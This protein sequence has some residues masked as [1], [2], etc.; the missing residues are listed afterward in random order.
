MS[1]QRQHISMDESSKELTSGRRFCRVLLLICVLT[2][3]SVAF[4]VAVVIIH[5]ARSG[6]RN[7]SPF[8]NHD[9][10]FDDDSI[11][12][13][14]APAATNKEGHRNIK[15]LS[16]STIEANATRAG[17]ES[18]V[19]LMRHCEK[20]GGPE[21]TDADGNE[22]C[23]YVGRERARWFPSLFGPGHRWPIPSYLYALSP[24]RG[25]SKLVFRSVESLT[26]LA[27]KFGL[28][29]HQDYQSNNELVKGVFEALSSGEACGKLTIVNWRHH[30]MP[31]LAMKLGCQFCP[32][33][34]PEHS[35]DEVW[36]LKFVWNVADTEI[37]RRK[38]ED[39]ENPSSSSS[40]M[41]PPPLL[42]RNLKKSK[43]EAATKTIE[44]DTMPL[45]TIYSTVTKQYFD[46]L[47]FS[48]MVGDYIEGGTETG[49]TWLSID[50]GEM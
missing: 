32:L 33:E 4:A 30:M 7:H 45:W 26:P 42:R 37:G 23:D 2:L 46:P 50:G 21:R 8:G 48:T 43:Y 22:H 14:S 35:F 10:D 27:D 17:C 25:D 31:N 16:K 38:N 6:G 44:K 19:L 24:T 5:S 28:A 13:V 18:T 34:Y 1:Y 15:K 39:A 11:H 36:Q 41:P 12:V 20:E 49:G 47:Q 3:S 9:S 29:I 40:P